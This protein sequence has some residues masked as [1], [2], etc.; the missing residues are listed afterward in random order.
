MVPGGDKDGPNTN[1][2]SR[3]TIS[4]VPAHHKYTLTRIRLLLCPIKV[5]HRRVSTNKDDVETVV[6]LCL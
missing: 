3:L 1:V 4:H 6:L 5:V 2:S